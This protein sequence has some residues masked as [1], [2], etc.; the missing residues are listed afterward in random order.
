MFSS[1]RERD[2]NYLTRSRDKKDV[3]I[4]LFLRKK[5]YFKKSMNIINPCV[6]LTGYW[7]MIVLNVWTN[8]V[9]VKHSKTQRQIV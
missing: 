7:P 8:Y 2:F 6:H 1:I 3:I 4:Y 5:K 9:S